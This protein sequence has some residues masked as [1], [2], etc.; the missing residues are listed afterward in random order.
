MCETVHEKWLNKI[1][2]ILLL[3]SNIQ[4]TWSD[5]KLMENKGGERGIVSGSLLVVVLQ[6]VPTFSFWNLILNCMGVLTI[7]TM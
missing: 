3:F 5:G 6:N 1:P 4:A 7:R 2:I